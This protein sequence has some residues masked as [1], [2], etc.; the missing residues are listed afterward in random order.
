MLRVDASAVAVSSGRLSSLH[1]VPNRVYPFLAVPPAAWLRGHGGLPDSI[2]ETSLSSP[3]GVSRDVQRVLLREVAQ[4]GGEAT[5]FSLATTFDGAGEPLLFVMLN[6]RDVDDFIDKEQRLQR[7]FHGGH[8]VRVVERDEHLIDLI[9]ESQHGTTDR[10]ESLYVLAIHLQSFE[11]IGCQGLSACLPESTEP[12]QPIFR[13]GTAAN[14]IPEGGHWRWRI[15]WTGFTRRR[16]PM[17]GLDEVLLESA[18]P[19]DLTANAEISTRL[20]RVLTTDLAHRWTV[21]EAALQ[22]HTSTRT[23]QRELS[24]AGTTFVK[25]LDVVRVEA[26]ARLLTDS[27]WAITEVGYLCG[28]SDSS[29]FSRRFK[30]RKGASPKAWREMQE[31]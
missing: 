18:A 11:L 7:F 23:L 21:A 19:L 28:F 13:N 10:A 30:L 6:S 27:A 9:H 5:L 31:T 17:A 29:H 3:D 2:D 25:L 16:E 24:A 22:L 20:T 4:R 14:A 8:Q 26:A 1:L 12:D 15:R